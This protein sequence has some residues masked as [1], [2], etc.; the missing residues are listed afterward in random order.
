MTYRNIFNS[1]Q[2][3]SN[4]DIPLLLQR[5]HDEEGRIFNNAKEKNE[6]PLL[7]HHYNLPHI[8]SDIHRSA[9]TEI[10]PLSYR[11]PTFPTLP[12]PSSVP[13]STSLSEYCGVPLR[14]P[15]SLS[16]SFSPYVSIDLPS[17]YLPQS[18]DSVHTPIESSS[19]VAPPPP[20]VTRKRA[21][22]PPSE[23]KRRGRL[24]GLKIGR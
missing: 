1:W 24:R 23:K 9:P 14:I 13:Y 18:T 11:L 19:P 5:T 3:E 22:P 8:S 4:F 2:S 20:A 7:G 21:A 6:I 15:S 10:F 16:P 12:R 17:P